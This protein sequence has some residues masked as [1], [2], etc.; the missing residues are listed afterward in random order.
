M[1]VALALACTPP[2]ALH[3]QATVYIESTFAGDG[4]TTTDAGTGFI[5]DPQGHV[6][7]AMH[8]VEPSEGWRLQS[9]TARVD[10]WPK[11]IPLKRVAESS[12]TD[13]ALLRLTGDRQAWPALPIGDAFAL[14]EGDP[15]VLVGFPRDLGRVVLD[16]RIAA[17]TGADKQADRLL[18]SVEISGGFSGGAVVDH[19]GCVVAVAVSRRRQGAYGYLTRINH[20]RNLLDVTRAR[21][22][23]AGPS[24]DLF[25]GAAALGGGVLLGLLA[26]LA[27]ARR[28]RPT[29]HAPSEAKTQPR[30]TATVGDDAQVHNSIIAGGDVHIGST[31]PPA[32]PQETSMPSGPTP[33]RLDDLF[34]WLFSSSEELHR[35]LSR[36]GYPN[37]D[38]LLSNLPS[39]Q[40]T[41]RAEYAFQAANQVH[42]HGV[43]AQVLATLIELRPQQRSVIEAVGRR[44]E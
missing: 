30:S 40:G 6:L 10:G 43:T 23:S 15:F 3:K 25:L 14:Q 33:E 38:Q 21:T 39:P 4:K 32:A 24:N 11:P 9:V 41:S 22:C 26:V 1:I 17:T 5:V 8:V 16:G 19:Q 31:S 42:S 2:H 44:G 29:S 34:E 36:V 12:T 27:W 13:L 28:K 35:A 18:A 7:T 20:A 37:M